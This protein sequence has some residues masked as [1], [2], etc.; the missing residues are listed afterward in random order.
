MHFKATIQARDEGDV[1]NF[2]CQHSKI[3]WVLLSKSVGV[4]VDT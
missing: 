4:T 2:Q 3:E 1:Q